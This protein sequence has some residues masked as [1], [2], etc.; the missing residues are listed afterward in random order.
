[1][2]LIQKTAKIVDLKIKFYDITKVKRSLSESSEEKTVDDEDQKEKTPKRVPKKFVFGPQPL[3]PLKPLFADLTARFQKP[4]EEDNVPV[5]IPVDSKDATLGQIDPTMYDSEPIHNI[6]MAQHPAGMP[7]FGGPILGQ[8]SPS[9]KEIEPHHNIQTGFP[10]IPAALPSLPLHFPV[11]GYPAHLTPALTTSL[12]MNVREKLDNL[13]LRTQQYPYQPA[14][15][16]HETESMR[17]TLKQI[18]QVNVN[19]RPER[20]T[21]GYILNNLV[22]QL[23]PMLRAEA[24]NAEVDGQEVVTEGMVAPNTKTKQSEHKS[25][26]NGKV[27]VELGKKTSTKS[28]TKKINTSEEDTTEQEV[29][30]TETASASSTTASTTTTTIP[31]ISLQPIEQVVPT[32]SMLPIEQIFTTPKPIKTQSTTP[33]FLSVEDDDEV[34]GAAAED[35]LY[36]DDHHL[37]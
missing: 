2:A 16:A 31:I 32:T 27:P 3:K 25:P 28:P 13:L 37:D 34:V 1:M 26:K 14:V 4:D 35:Y 12:L 18:T 9:I 17:N 8:M 7:L 21:W 33:K 36:E 11:H 5:E 20:K 15:T 29:H 23:A 10:S 30:S 6:N 19:V 24:P 22:N